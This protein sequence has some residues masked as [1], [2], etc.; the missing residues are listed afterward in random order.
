MH[1]SA[2]ELID[3]PGF[4]R[5]EAQ[6]RSLGALPHA[7]DVLEY[8]AELRCG[9]IRVDNEPGFLFDW[10]RKPPCLQLVAV[11]SSTAALP[12]YG[13][14]YGFTGRPIPDYG[15]FPLVCDADCGDLGGLQARSSKGFPCD[16]KLSIKYGICIMLNPTG[17]GV[18]L[19]ELLLCGAYHLAFCIK[20]D[21]SAARSACIK[22][23]N[24]FLCHIGTCL[25]F[26][27]RGFGKLYHCIRINSIFIIKIGMKK[28]L[29]SALNRQRNDCG[30]ATI[31]LRLS[32]QKSLAGLMI[33]KHCMVLLMKSLRALRGKRCCDTEICCSVLFR[34]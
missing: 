29:F 7:G 32:P 8:P 5:T 13:I 4:D 25:F 14:G 30:R 12:D 24:A 34:C 17:L 9:E 6:L 11:F 26:S 20:K 15:R 21:A 1:L 10:L 27:H 2:R 16:L 18:D 31:L 23:H 33:W 22:R 3:E 19:H 28:P